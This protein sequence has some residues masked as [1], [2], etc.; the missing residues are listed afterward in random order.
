MAAYNIDSC[1]LTNVTSKESGTVVYSVAT[2]IDFSVSSCTITCQATYDISTIRNTLAID[3]YTTG[4]VFYFS[5]AD[6]LTSSDNTY[7]KCFTGDKGGI[8]TLINVNKL[9][10]RGSQYL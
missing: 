3:S 9:T 10:E 8:F 7:Q 5:G 2:N 1:Q 4:G 6:Q